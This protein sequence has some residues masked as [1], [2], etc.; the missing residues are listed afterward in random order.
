MVSKNQP[1]DAAN[2]QHLTVALNQAL[3]KNGTYSDPVGVFNA[4]PVVP[5][6]NP[7]NLAYP[8]PPGNVPAFVQNIGVRVAGYTLNPSVANRTVSYANGT[9]TINWP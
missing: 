2:P 9:L 6:G 1:P 4:G 8:A 7:G 5:I 3:A